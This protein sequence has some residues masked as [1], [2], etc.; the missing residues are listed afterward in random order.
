MAGKIYPVRQPRIV[1]S[2]CW[3]GED[4]RVSK[5]DVYGILKV[6]AEPGLGYTERVYV[7]AQEDDIP[8]ANYNLDSDIVDPGEVWVLT[9]GSVSYKGTVAGVEI[10]QGGLHP[11]SG[12]FT[13]YQSPPVSD[14]WYAWTGMI[15]LKEGD[16][17]RTRV[18]GGTIND[19][20]KGRAAGY[21]MKVNQTY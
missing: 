16:A 3:D 2:V 21:I 9:Y 19:Q 5:C 18:E 6:R 10:M 4:Y 17:L 20:L 14:V 12:P 15:I 7:L 8:T 11:S 1:S 13:I